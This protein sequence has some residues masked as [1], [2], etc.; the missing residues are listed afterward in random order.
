M[1]KIHQ[2]MWEL[3]QKTK[4]HVARFYGPWH[5]EPWINTTSV[6]LWKH[7]VV[8]GADERRIGAVDDV[9]G[10]ETGRRGRGRHI[11]RRR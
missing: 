9:P 1:Q 4:W 6:Q 7:A 3:S 2:E 5:I 8:T 10:V 11:R